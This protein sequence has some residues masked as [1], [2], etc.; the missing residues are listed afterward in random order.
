MLYHVPPTNPIDN[1]WT[2]QS[3]EMYIRPG[4]CTGVM[5]RHPKL[6]WMTASG[7]YSRLSGTAEVLSFAV[8][9]MD[10]HSIMDSMDDDDSEGEDLF[11][12]SITTNS[13][14]VHLFECPT[15][16]ERDRIVSG[17]KNIIARMSFSLVAGD[18]VVM[19]ELY[20]GDEEEEGELPSLRTPQQEMATVSHEFLDSIA[21]GVVPKRTTST[22]IEV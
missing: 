7:G 16:D 5:T 18:E 6:V 13:G 4:D 11:F 20:G 10:I 17:I 2:G 8:G 22:L 14:D 15:E 1:D 19:S 12:F 3:M 21:P 9:L